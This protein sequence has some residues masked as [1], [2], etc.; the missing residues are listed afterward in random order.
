MILLVKAVNWPFSLHGRIHRMHSTK[1]SITLSGQLITNDLRVNQL[2]SD[3][4]MLYIHM[5]ASSG[6]C[7]AV[8]LCSFSFARDGREATNGSFDAAHSLDC[9]ADCSELFLTPTGHQDHP[10]ARGHRHRQ[11]LPSD[12]LS[13]EILVSQ[14]S[15]DRRQRRSAPTHSEAKRLQYSGHPL[16]DR[17]T[18]RPLSPSSIR[19]HQA[20][21]AEAGRNAAA[22]T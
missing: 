3:R 10:L 9:C 14:I 16:M 4:V 12:R 7:A 21:T 11:D 1:S 6:G 13:A 8:T 20:L 19:P 5:K 2:S 17:P 18:R 22:R 15:Q